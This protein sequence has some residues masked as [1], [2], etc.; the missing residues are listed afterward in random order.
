MLTEVFHQQSLARKAFITPLLNKSLKPTLNT[1]VSDEWLYSEKFR[2]LVKEAKTIEK[3]VT[4]IKRQDNPNKN[5]MVSHNQGNRKG[6][7]A[8]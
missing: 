6:P 5:S 2:D 8:N 1:T 3:A 7:P 4:G